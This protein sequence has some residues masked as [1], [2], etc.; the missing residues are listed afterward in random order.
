MDTNFVSVGRQYIAYALGIKQYEASSTRVIWEALYLLRSAHCKAT[1]ERS[2]VDSE[3]AC[4]IQWNSIIYLLS[5][6]HRGSG[7][8]LRTMFGFH[9]P[10]VGMRRPQKTGD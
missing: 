9:R 8:R 1:G 5:N 3:P 7:F 2:K 6:N 10:T 4:F